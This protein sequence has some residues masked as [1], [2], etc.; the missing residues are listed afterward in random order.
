MCAQ[1]GGPQVGL[2]LEKP[3][4]N[5]EEA[6]KVVVFKE[7]KDLKGLPAKF[8]SQVQQCMAKSAIV[9]GRRKLPEGRFKNHYL[10]LARRVVQSAKWATKAM[11]GSTAPPT[12]ESQT[13]R[14]PNFWENTF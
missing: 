10:N 2:I 12:K 3:L 14:K 6:E 9:A 1:R 8:L 11:R 5:L 4:E 13:R 7:A